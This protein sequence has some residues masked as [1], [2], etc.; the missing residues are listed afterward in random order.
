MS[1]MLTIICLYIQLGIHREQMGAKTTDWQIMSLY[2]MGGALNVGDGECA[3][4]RQ[5]VCVMIDMAMEDRKLPNTKD[6]VCRRAKIV[7][8]WGEWGLSS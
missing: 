2:M 4:G 8:T 1:T 7:S 6:M 3:K 5:R